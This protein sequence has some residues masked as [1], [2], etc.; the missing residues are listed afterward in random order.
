M[1][2]K[3]LNLHNFRCFDDLEVEFHDKLSVIVG[4][5]GAGKTTIL[6]AAAIAVGTLLYSLDGVINYGIK[7][8]D[9]HNKYFNMGSVVDV[10]PQ[11]PVEISA[12]GIAD[13][14]SVKWTR[15]LNSENG[16]TT[17]IDAKEMTKISEEY[18]K[19]MMKGDTSLVLPIVAYY[20]TG[21]L[22]DYHREKKTDTFK[23]S[24]RS[25]GYID[26]LDGTANIKLMMNWF[27][28][29]AWTDGQSEKP[30]PE[31]TAVR[32]A[33]ERCFSLMTGIEDV[34]VQFNPDTSE[35]DIIYRS[36]EEGSIKIPLNQLSDGYK[37][38][39]S[40]IADIAYRMAV[41]NPWL[42][43]RILTETNGVVLIDEVDLHL[44]PA[45]QQRVINDL[46]S[47]FPMVQFIVTTHAPAVI[48]SVKSDNLIILKD[49]QILRLDNQVYGKDVKS[50]LNEIMGVTERPPEVAKLFTAFYKQLAGKN[51]DKADQTLNQIDELRGYH[52]QEVAGCRVKLKLERIRGGQA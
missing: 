49:L 21:R 9:A 39:I 44:H 3:K 7:K 17:V 1:N 50:V 33:M 5:N 14:T 40:L 26:C 28:K 15:S 47:I 27:K 29:M 24:N 12:C 19:R 32:G 43:D 18:Q 45:W 34:K 10:Q 48:N 35:I 6:E 36:N 46:T 25:N 31:F 13:D 4:A 22:W 51:F 11:Y 42:S 20:G 38:T 16:K 30:S 2:L 52:D 37:G 8:T 41:L 23:K